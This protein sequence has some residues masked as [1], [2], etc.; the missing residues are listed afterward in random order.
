M[1]ARIFINYRRD[2]SNWISLAIYNEL[3]KYFAKECIFKDFNTIEPGCDFVLAIDDALTDCDVLLVIIGEKWLSVVNEYGMP[4]V[5]DPCD[6][7]RIEIAKAL[8][9]RKKVIPILIDNAKMPYDADLPEDIKPLLRRQAFAIDPQR[10][11]MDMQKLAEIILGKHIDL[12][13]SNMSDKSFVEI[14]DNPLDENSSSIHKASNDICFAAG[15]I[16][17]TY[18]IFADN[19]AEVLSDEMQI[20]IIRTGGS[21]ESLDL[22]LD[23]SV[24]FDF[25]IM[26]YD[27]LQEYQSEIND[28]IKMV[29]P[30]YDE[31]F[32]LLVRKATGISRLED[33]SGKRVALAIKGGAYHTAKRIREVT[34]LKFEI[35]GRESKEAFED[36]NSRKVDAIYRNDGVPSEN[37]GGLSAT[38]AKFYKLVNIKHHKL[39]TLYKRSIIRGGDYFWCKDDVETYSVKSILVCRNYPKGDAGYDMIKKF[40]QGIIDN[41]D[42]LQNFCHIKWQSLNLNDY[43][44]IPIELHDAA[45]E[46]LKTNK[47]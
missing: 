19:I 46:V 7:V 37:F 12:A 22:L 9:K 30:L 41:L 15:N 33:L 10:F 36:L 32:H 24:N 16:G 31:E 29:L 35:V 21:K 44:S 20:N 8:E 13:T 11:E 6:Y 14:L 3:L 39:D 43:Q 17:S 5:N 38:A 42:A 2:D 47:L 45:K 18:G 23:N 4:R 34:G 1:D 26:Q 27:I 40:T 28:K 25:A